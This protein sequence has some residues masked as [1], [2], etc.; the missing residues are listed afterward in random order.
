M[1]TDLK[2]RG[3]TLTPF[4]CAAVEAGARDFAA[5]F[6]KLETSLRVRLFDMNGQ[7]GGR[8][9][10]CL[11]NARVGRETATA[12]GLDSDL[13][14]AI[15]IAFEK[16]ERDTGTTLRRARASRRRGAKRSPGTES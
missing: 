2:S 16:L 5:R 10:V 13:Y 14:R 12:S 7:R 1:R 15:S 4:L 8:D 9:K 11:V 3:F 6:P